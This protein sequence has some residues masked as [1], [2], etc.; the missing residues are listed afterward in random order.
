MSIRLFSRRTRPEVAF[1]LGG[2]GNLGSVQVGQLR[3]LLER[4]IV[5]DVVIGCSVGAL[6]GAAIAGNPTN[7]EAIRLGALWSRLTRDDIF[8]S[9][10]MTKGPWRFVR[11]GVSAY[12]DTGLR[13]IIERWLRFSRF[14]DAALPL[15]VVATSIDTGREHWFNAGDV[16]Q[17]LLASTAL[18]GFF[19]PVTLGD[20]RFVDGGVVNNVPIS[21]AVELG[22]RKI[23][24]LDVGNVTRDQPTPKRPYEVLQMAVGI[25]RAY[26]FREDLD[27]VPADT[28]VYRLPGVDPGSLRFDD[29][30]RS[31]D[32]IERGYAATTIYLDHPI[33]ANG[34][35][36]AS[37]PEPPTRSH[38]G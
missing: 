33:A 35:P 23:Y 10:A 34:R 32:L 25:A 8:P 28:E 27:Q 24:V 5:P 7:Q 17:A 15:W 31:A 38:A 2:G 13:G 6:N 14:E 30:S 19:P 21:K 26:R 12:P 9:S 36:V 11:N 29:F 22:A 16:A 20:D 18:P 3:A 4:G 37:D 1:V